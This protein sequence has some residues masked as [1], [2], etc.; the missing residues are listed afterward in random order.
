MA[1]SG[2]LIPSVGVAAAFVLAGL[3]PG[4]ASAAESAEVKKFDFNRLS[5]KQELW[6]GAIETFADLPRRLPQDAGYSR[7]VLEKVVG[8]TPTCLAEGAGYFLSEAI[9]EG[10]IKGG[11]AP[12]GEGQTQADASPYTNVT[13]SKR[14]RPVG[15]T[16]ESNASDMN[17][18]L[19]SSGNG[20]LWTSNCNDDLSS[21]TATGDLINASGFRFAGSTVSGAV[22]QRTG[23]YTA[24]AR[25]Y[26]VGLEGAFD[27]LSSVFQISY[28][29]GSVATAVAPTITYRMSLFDSGAGQSAFANDGFTLGGTEVPAGDLVDQFN[30]QAAQFAAGAQAIGPLGFQLLAPEVYRDP[31]TGQQSITA[32]AVVGNVGLASQ[33]GGAGQNVGVRLASITWTGDNTYID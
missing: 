31:G 23:T 3:L 28:R 11:A 20:P 13:Q 33:A 17:P 9:E 27:S 21:G 25:A 1:R 7:L 5:Y 4:S 15:G 2:K 19:P 18:A 30:S 22:D 10:I 24:T 8:S 32:P 16:G 26:V 12:I 14:V 6:A 29:P